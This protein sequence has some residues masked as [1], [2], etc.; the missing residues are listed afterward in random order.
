M[1]PHAD[2]S[3]RLDSL[4]LRL[5]LSNEE[6]AKAAVQGLACHM[7]SAALRQLT[8][9]FDTRQHNK[10][11]DSDYSTDN[12][13]LI[14]TRLLRH[15]RPRVRPQP[16]AGPLRI[17]ASP[18][19]PDSIATIDQ[20]E[21]VEMVDGAAKE[22]VEQCSPMMSQLAAA[23][24]GRPVWVDTDRV[25]GVNPR[26]YE[27]VGNPRLQRRHISAECLW[28]ITEPPPAQAGMRKRKRQA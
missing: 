3:V 24:R 5:S 13:V 11:S 7:D 23:T 20:Y 22:S 14:T 19:A 28:H 26:F 2:S 21:G 18:L 25:C 4:I 15:L 8:I 10:V 17:T 12:P 27:I 6:E 16:T 1:R 9:A